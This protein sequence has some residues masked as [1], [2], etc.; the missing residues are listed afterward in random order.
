MET[1]PTILLHY[2]CVSYPR[3]SWRSGLAGQMQ[4]FKTPIKACN[5]VKID[6]WKKRQAWVVPG[7]CWLFGDSWEWQRWVKCEPCAWAPESVPT[8][9]PKPLSCTQSCWNVSKS[10]P[11]SLKIL[12][13]NNRSLRDP[14]RL[15][16][17]D[18]TR[19]GRRSGDGGPAV[20]LQRKKNLKKNVEPVEV[21]WPLCIWIRWRRASTV[22]RVSGYGGPGR[23]ARWWATATACTHRKL[24]PKIA[25][26]VEWRSPPSILRSS[27]FLSPLLLLCIAPTYRSDPRSCLLTLKPLESIYV[28]GFGTWNL[29]TG[30]CVIT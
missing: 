14:T 10:L 15:A 20:V 17:I 12:S 2:S 6:I 22:G 16:E 21:L 25:V 28:A 18:H 23:P 13:Y 26:A 30:V 29:W 19:E 3:K 27:S 9:S 24:A 4:A 1:H 8:P 5:K 11:K 7:E